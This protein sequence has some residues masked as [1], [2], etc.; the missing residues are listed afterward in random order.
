[1][2]RLHN[3]GR[4]LTDADKTFH[5]VF[6]DQVARAPNA[7]AVRSENM[8]MSYRELD[9]RANQLAHLLH[10]RGVG[11]E[12]TVGLCLDRDVPLAVG[13]LGVL[14]AG[15]AYVPVDPNEAPARRDNIFAD[16]DVQALITS[17]GNV[18]AHSREIVRLNPTWSVLEGQPSEGPP[19]VTT[20]LVHAAYLL[21]TSGS[22]GPPKG[23]VVEHRQLMAYTRAALDRF[24]I[25]EPLNYAMVQPLSVD[26]SVTSF[27]LPLC[28]GGEVHLLSRETSLDVERLADWARAHRV[29]FLKIAPSHLRAL[30]SSTRFA[31]LLPRKMLVVGGE[32]ADWQWLQSLQ[33]MAPD[34]RVVNHYG[35]TETTVGVLTLTVADH[36][37]A[38]W[39]TSPIGIPLPGIRAEIID[40]HGDP[41][42]TGTVGELVISGDNLARGYHRRPDVTAATFVADNAGVRRYRTGDYVYRHTDGVIAYVSRRDDQIKVRGYR[43]E[44]GEIDAALRSHTEVR[45]A[46]TLVRED[47]PGDRRIVAYIEPDGIATDHVAQHLRSRLPPYMIPQQIVAMAR[48][49]LSGHGKVDR[50]ALPTPA[51]PEIKQPSSLTN[52]DHLVIEA[53]KAVLGTED[54]S[55]DQNF[56]DLGGHSLLLTELQHRLRVTTGREVELLDLFHYTTVGAQASFLAG[57][58]QETHEGPRGVAV[59]PPRRRLPPRA[60]RG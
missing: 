22:T 43:V 16:A 28:T 39:H 33:R 15:G 13:V 17:D 26:S 52:L 48:L 56:F 60:K 38:E 57:K 24:E 19:A 55:M 8:S 37:D 47:V 2:T 9:Q 31:E 34:C 18:I 54:V 51:R 1:M 41:A 10:D 42:P 30:E 36:P 29:D 45:N 6:Q 59:T 20:S 27:M 7:T 49:P 40:Q 53:W 21:Y 50:N 4:G 23:V 44:L 3:A 32:A 14:K 46:V 5:Q 58:T 12:V 11:P 25:A 35:P